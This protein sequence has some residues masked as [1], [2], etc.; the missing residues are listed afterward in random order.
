MDKKHKILSLGQWGLPGNIDPLVIAGP[1]SAE[2]EEQ[3]LETARLLAGLGIRIFRAGIWKPR[4]RPN[5]F[6]GVGTEGLQWLRKVKATTGMLTATEVANRQHVFEA[7]KHG[8][9]IL[10]IGARTTVN[11]FAVQEIADALSGV[12]IPVLIK[13]PLNPDIELWIGAIERILEAGITRVG[14]IH[15]GFSAYGKNEYRNPP[16]WQVPIDLHRRLPDLPLLVDPSHICGNRILLKDITQRSLDLNFNGLIIESHHN[17]DYAW[18]DASQQITPDA[19]ASLLDSIVVRKEQTN[20]ASIIQNI[21][22]LR[23]QIDKIDEDLIELLARRMELSESIGR[24]KMKNNIKIL[25]QSRWQAIID[26]AVKRGNER[27]LSTGFIESVF[28]TIHQ[29]SINKQLN[30]LSTDHLQGN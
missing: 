2:T 17:P 23:T 1:C 5:S 29:E 28:Q 15:R 25:Q 6:E 4:T 27:N 16:H 24:Y 12:D 21:E 9:D 30:I 10:W 7:L 11:P 19:L 13:N 26:R 18:S 20:D 3:V 14:A 8:I 22:E